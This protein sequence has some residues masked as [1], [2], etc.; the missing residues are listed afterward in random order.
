MLWREKDDREEW[1]GEEEMKGKREGR[2]YLPVGRGMRREEL[3]E[4]L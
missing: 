1:L 3:E 4:L 2:A